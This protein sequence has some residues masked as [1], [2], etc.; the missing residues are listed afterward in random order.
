MCT[1]AAANGARHKALVNQKMTKDEAAKILNVE[2]EA[3]LEDVME[4]SA[5]HLGSA[6]SPDMSLYD[7]EV[8]SSLWPDAGDA[9]TI[10]SA[11]S[12]SSRT[13]TLPRVGQHTCNRRNPPARTLAW[14]LVCA[15]SL[16]RREFRQFFCARCMLSSSL[17]G[18]SRLRRAS[19]RKALAA[20]HQREMLASQKHPRVRVLCASYENSPCV[21]SY[22]RLALLPGWRY[23][24]QGV[25]PVRPPP[26]AETDLSFVSS[27]A[28]SRRQRGKNANALY[29][30]TEK[31]GSPT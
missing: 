28:P 14:N 8:H 21:R 22:F 20:L 12:I 3:A 23:L 6:V 27:C 10:G 30:P 31:W 2:R 24:L 19:C 17:F 18:R 26:R 25:R 5:L 7:T 29:K 11:I 4:V 16:S 15:H 1:D 9:C 13:T